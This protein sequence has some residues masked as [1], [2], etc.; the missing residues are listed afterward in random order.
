MALGVY[1]W[2]CGG[3]IVGCALVGAWKDWRER[4]IPNLLT[5]PSALVG[6]VCWTLAGGVRGFLLS[7]GAWA[8]GLA[9]LLPFFALG[10]IGAG[11][12]KF[13][14][15]FG[16]LGGPVFLVE[17]FLAGASAG[18]LL[19]LVRTA[20][21]GREAFASLWSSL[22]SG[23]FLLQS[24]E[25]RS[26]EENVPYGM[27]LAFGAVLALCHLVWSGGFKVGRW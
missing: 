22:M 23:A 16:A 13:L 19:V 21:G 15:A 25:D 7:S 18:L 8:G 17:T 4:R 24:T 14:A 5:L 26:R 10:G 12:V 11:D 20:A 6:V 1:E 27:A 3:M 9:L 2:I